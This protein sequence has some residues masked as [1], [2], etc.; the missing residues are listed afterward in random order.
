[1]IFKQNAKNLGV[2]PLHLED[3]GIEIH[4]AYSNDCT[5]SITL[6]PSITVMCCGLTPK[7]GWRQ[8][9]TEASFPWPLSTTFLGKVV[10]SG[11]SDTLYKVVISTVLVTLYLLTTLNIGAIFGTLDS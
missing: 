4:I 6:S 3:N 9:G 8:R 1:M 11:L 7:L 10:D 5:S 2:C